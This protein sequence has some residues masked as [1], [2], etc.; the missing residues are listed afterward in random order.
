MMRKLAA[1]TAVLLLTTLPAAALQVY[2]QGDP[3]VPRI[4]ITVDD[5][6]DIDILIRMLDL[7]EQESACVTIFPIGSRIRPEDRDVWR[8]VLADGHEIGNHSQGHRNFN[9]LTRRQIYDELTRAQSR[10]DDAL[11]YAYPM[12]L[13]RPPYGSF[14]AEHTLS[15]I[16]AAGYDKVIFWSVSQTNPEAAM[17]AIRAGSVCLFHTN[18]RDLRC[19]A[20][21]IPQLK[22]KGF[23]LVTVSELF[24]FAEPE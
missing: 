7:F 5:C 11:G 4:A 23:E 14:N 2:K 24:G 6:F 12:T 20:E 1:L 8:R 13:M 10:L 21:I 19:L 18:A 17:D 22:E 16:R 9:N 15:Y 3:K